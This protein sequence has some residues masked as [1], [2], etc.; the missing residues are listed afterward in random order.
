MDDTWYDFFI[1][2]LYKKFP[3]KMQLAQA[4]TNLLF[5]ER[6]AVYRRLRKDVPFTVYE[7]AK[8]SSTWNIS[9]DEIIHAGSGNV[10]FTMKPINYIDPSDTELV[11]VQKRIQRLEH[12]ETAA[13]AECMEVCNK[14]PR[15]LIAG[16]PPLYQFKI[17]RW[18]YEYGNLEENMLFSQIRFPEY[19]SQELESYSRLIKNV[20]EMT[21]V[22]DLRLFEYIVSDIQF[23]HSILLVSDEE[24]DL[25][26]KELLAL[27][28]YLHEVAT[29]GAFPETNNK[30]TICISKINIDTNYS[31]FYTDDLR[32][33]RIHA[34]EKYDI[35]SFNEEMVNNFRNWMQLKKRISTQISEVDEK[36]RIEFFMKQR[37][38]VE[39]L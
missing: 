38:L 35:F 11:E 4:L 33:C 8:I 18:A 16:F 9:L 27:L 14:L 32:M 28:D 17:F 24:K 21:Y 10:A 13:D 23:F 3:Q 19:A 30:V 36:S 2:A 37:Q 29:K 25:L 15:S 26:K 5:I 31:Y 34:F 7:M 1:E 20:A 22:W 39:K 12:L 6:E